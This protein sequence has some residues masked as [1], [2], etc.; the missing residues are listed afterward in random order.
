MKP[1]IEYVLS[2]LKRATATGKK[3]HF[4]DEQFL[5]SLQDTDDIPL[6]VA[7]AFLLTDMAMIDG[8]FDA[9]EHVFLLEQ[10]GKTFNLST[11]ELSALTDQA[12]TMLATARGASSYA[13]YVRDHFTAEQRTQMLELIRGMVAAD[14]VEDAHETYLVK[15]FSMALGLDK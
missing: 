12:R 4:E 7:C 11:A 10:L 6:P 13:D 3:Q 2:I 9:K 1:V 14:A 15:H 8:S 5:L